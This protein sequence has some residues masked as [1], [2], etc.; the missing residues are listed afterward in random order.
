[1]SLNAKNRK[2]S[3][4]TRLKISESLKGRIY[5]NPDIQK[6]EAIKGNRRKSVIYR[7]VNLINGKSYIG[8]SSNTEKRRWL[9]PRN[10]GLPTAL[11]IFSPQAVLVKKKKTNKYIK[12]V[13]FHS[14]PS[15]HK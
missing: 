8:S 12:I 11:I 2:N 6:I 4:E 9:E 5:S 10:S 3:I 1:M 7:R 13:F 15:S 14:D